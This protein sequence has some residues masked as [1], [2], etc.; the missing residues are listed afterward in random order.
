M[1]ILRATLSGVL[2]ALGLRT[3]MQDPRV[4]MSSFEALTIGVKERLDPKHGTEKLTPG[5]V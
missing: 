1:R 3:R 5:N 4:F 2:L